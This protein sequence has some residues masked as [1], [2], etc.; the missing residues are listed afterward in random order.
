M[1][2]IESLLPQK[3]TTPTGVAHSRNDSP[4]AIVSTDLTRVT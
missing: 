3:A 4:S 1:F 2:V